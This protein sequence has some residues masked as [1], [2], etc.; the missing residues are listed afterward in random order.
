MKNNWQTKKLGEVCNFEGGSQP[1]KS[2]FIYEPKEGYVRFLQIRDFAS[3]KYVTYIPDSKKNRYCDVDD[4]LLGRYGASVGKI[5]INKKGAYNVAVMKT[6]PNT[7]VLDKSYFYYYLVSDEFQGPLSKVASRSAQAGF[8]K[9]DIY[10]FPVLTPPLQEQKKI[11]MLLDEAFEKISKVKDNARKNLQYSK[12]IFES[13]LQNV[14]ID[15]IDEW[16]YDRLGNVCDTGAGGTPLKSHNDYYEGGTIPWLRSGEVDKKEICESELFITPKGVA[17]SSAKLFPINTVLIAMYGATAGQVGIL[18]FEATTNQA[19][20]G[21]L[22]S[23]DFLPE[24]IYYVFLAKKKELVDQAVG[25]AQ[26]NIS[27][28]K[29]KN[30]KIPIPT[31]SEQ[32]KIIE[33]LDLLSKQAKRLEANYKQKIADLDELKKSL[34]TKAF[35]GEL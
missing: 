22:P 13:Y 27:Q 18:R 29:I 19:I 12:E 25:G 28:I 11:V 33:K 30:T 6:I 10:N 21:I 35:A 24:F 9:D 15:S 23:K 16:K 8:S 5:L 2:N 3:D 32:A 20:C 26:P 1:P 34:L 4:I 31:L 17:N 7:Q 14:F